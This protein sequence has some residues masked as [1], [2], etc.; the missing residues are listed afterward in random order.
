M[1]EEWRKHGNKCTCLCITRIQKNIQNPT[2]FAAETVTLTVIRIFWTR[3]FLPNLY[4]GFCWSLYRS[5]KG[6]LGY[7]R[8]W[9]ILFRRWFFT[10]R[11]L[12]YLNCG[13]LLG[14]F[15]WRWSLDRHCRRKTTLNDR[16]WIVSS[17]AYTMLKLLNK[18]MERPG[19]ET[20]VALCDGPSQKCQQKTWINSQSAGWQWNQ[21]SE[22][23]GVPRHS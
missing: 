13:C 19:E 10:W 17:S 5:F 6:S 15:L 21:K 12:L 14:E 23:D 11:L 2:L 8:F 9:L 1:E 3:I 18:E 4:C 20:D 16:M 7:F 22:H